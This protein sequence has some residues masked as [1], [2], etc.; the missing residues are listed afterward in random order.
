MQIVQRHE[1]N[2]SGV[3]FKEEN[4]RI[5]DLEGT[6]RR[7][8][9]WEEEKCRLKRRAIWLSQ[10]DQNMFFF[11]KIMQSMKEAK[12]RRVMRFQFIV[13]LEVFHFISLY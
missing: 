7:T 9:E 13:F 3:L 2:N 4:I 5:K 12:G 8:M 10:R 11:F 1:K 6:S